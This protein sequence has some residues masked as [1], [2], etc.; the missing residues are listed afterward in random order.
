MSLHIRLYAFGQVDRKLPVDR[1]RL[2]QRQL[3]GCSS[4]QQ[5]MRAFPG[6]IASGWI[7]DIPK[8][9]ANVFNLPILLKNSVTVLSSMF[10][11]VLHHFSRVRSSILQRS[12]RPIF[13]CRKSCPEAIEFFNRVC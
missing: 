10:S 2:G 7:G 12:E 3:C 4:Q 11:G 1:T 5:T 13:S 8:S 9:H 6:T